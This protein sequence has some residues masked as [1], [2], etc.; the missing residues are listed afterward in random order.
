MIIKVK[1]E[2][3]C[4]SYFEGDSVIISKSKKDEGTQPETLYLTSIVKGSTEY[5]SMYIK[6]EKKV[7]NR[8]FTNLPTY[9]MN[10]NGKTVDKLI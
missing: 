2:D 1:R 4:W 3:G 9:L 6:K 5:L 7:I 8:L 10:D